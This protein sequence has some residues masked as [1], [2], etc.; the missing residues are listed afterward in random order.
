[1]KL[2]KIYAFV[3]MQ[4]YFIPLCFSEK[5]EER[6][7]LRTTL[8]FPSQTNKKIQLKI[9]Y[10]SAIASEIQLLKEMSRQAALK[11]EEI[12][13]M[14]FQDDFSIIFSSRENIHNGK[15]T[16]VPR[17][18]I[19][20]YTK[21]PSISGDLAFDSDYIYSTLVHEM[22][23]MICIQQRRGIYKIASYLIG[24]T[25]R[26]TATWPIWI[27]EGI[28]TWAEAQIGGRKESG[29]VHFYE[30]L[31]NEYTQRNKKFPISNHH[32][33]GPRAL[34]ASRAGS[35][36]YLFGY[37]LINQLFQKKESMQRFLKL[38]ANS[39]GYSFRINLRALK[40]NLSEEQNKSFQNIS[41]IP[42]SPNIPSRKIL[43]KKSI[44]GPFASADSSSA[45]Y[46]HEKSNSYKIIRLDT[47]KTQKKLKFS[48]KKNSLHLMKVIYLEQEKEWL[49]LQQQSAINSNL[50]SKY[51]FTRF[52]PQGKKICS[53][54]AFYKILDFQYSNKSLYLLKS[55]NTVQEKLFKTN[56]SSSCRNT[57]EKTLYSS[58]K[59]SRLNIFGDMKDNS[60]SLLSSEARNSYINTIHD[61]KRKK[62]ILVKRA[63]SNVLFLENSHCLNPSSTRCFL[64][65]TQNKN[66]RGLLYVEEL[67]DQLNYF[68]FPNST[69]FAPQYSYNKK[70]GLISAKK[71]RWEEDILV[72]FPLS[73]AVPEKEIISQEKVSLFKK[74]ELESS[75]NSSND[76]NPWKTILP[77]FW[78]PGFL[79]TGDGFFLSGSTL[80]SDASEIFQGEVAAGYDSFTQSPFASLL[81]QKSEF[82]TLV[83]DQLSFSTFYAPQN[84]LGS[85][86]DRWSLQTALSAKNYLGKN[87]YLKFILNYQFINGSATSP[88]RAFSYHI[89]SFK[90]HL[91]SALAQ[92][93]K[94]VSFK[95]NQLQWAFRTSVGL[96]FIESTSLSSQLEFQGK[97]GNTGFFMG[98]EFFSTHKK[99]FPVEYFEWGGR[100]FFSMQESSNLN[101]SFRQRISPATD[102]L[103]LYGEWGFKFFDIDRSLSWNRAHI[104]DLHLR[105]YYENVSPTL[106]SKITS[107]GDLS[108]KSRQ[109]GRDFFQSAG[110]E[111]DL[112]FQVFHYID[113][114]ASLGYSHPLD[115]FG[116][117]QV[118]ILLQSNLDL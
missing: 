59:F 55:T 81:L 108:N 18:R 83:F 56:F 111:I 85:I 42:L 5:K 20:V 1:M 4:L 82:H 67:N 27:H 43:K 115:N 74:T 3:L 46:F 8:S 84:I 36:P 31:F 106:Y 49:A 89:P 110:A 47:K 23:H 118:S 96:K 58:L 105:F 2:I 63:I 61:T 34:P 107:L 48:L 24:N 66:Y 26:P 60:F 25:S 10:P 65:W 12:F 7:N 53:S 116:K 73:S 9:F 80:F 50:K 104:E 79:V 95:I 21:A 29:T 113:F 38:S 32:F 51:F 33:D 76:Y 68:N 54:Q 40:K 93:T 11:T 109:L 13:Q 87:H 44:A 6:I 69:G 14:P 92:N 70:N 39:L 17:N 75:K 117:S 22:A 37:L 71:E 16:V 35:T 99:N 77:K 52:T 91:N 41:K 64:A 100:P 45:F 88:L 101:R 28:A 62:N 86:Q 103:R 94:A 30:R 72:E 97:M 15:A 102:L 98:S 19:Y 114:K 90:V 57:K 78:Y 112:F